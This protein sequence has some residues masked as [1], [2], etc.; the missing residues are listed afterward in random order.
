MIY[1]FDIDGTLCDLEHRLHHV[2]KHPKDWDS[3]FAG[4]ADDLPI[5]EVLDVAK[6]LYSAGHTLLLV[7]GRSHDVRQQ[8]KDWFVGRDLAHMFANLYMRKAG[9][10]RPDNIVKAE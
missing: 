1:I 5:P 3:F 10:H 6:A 7:S 2:K 8:T 9:D 4:V